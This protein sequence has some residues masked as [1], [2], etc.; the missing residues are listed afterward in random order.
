MRADHVGLGRA[1]VVVQAGRRQAREHRADGR[2]QAQLL[3]G[4]DHLGEVFAQAGDGGVVGVGQRIGQRAQRQ[5]RQVQALDPT[6]VQGAGERGEVVAQS[7]FGDDQGRA[8]AQRAEDFLERDVETE[9]GEL[10]GAQARAE[11]AALPAQQ[12]QQRRVRH[13]HA[14]GAAG[15]SGGVDHV[16][17]ALRVVAVRVPGVAVG[18]GGLRVGRE[19]GAVVHGDPGPIV[20]VARIVQAQRAPSGCVVQARS[21]RGIVQQQ[22]QPCARIVGVQRQV[23]SAGLE[24]GQHR[25]HR[26]ESALGADRDAVAGDDAERAQAP[27][28][29][30]GAGVERG[31]AQRASGMFQCRRMRCALGLA[32]EQRVHAAALGGVFV[33]GVRGRRN[34]VVRT[35]L[36]HGL[37]AMVG[38]SVGDPAPQ[39]RWRYSQ[40]AQRR[41][42]SRS[43]GGL[44]AGSSSSVMALPTTVSP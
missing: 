28:Q 1:V 20:A 9:R 7:G 35:D 3:A 34:R 11:L 21:G 26:R 42:C 14:L 2:G 12:V 31:V 41:R 43:S 17:R 30:L 25:H 19:V 18:C 29:P 10:Q 5:V 27:R 44:A 8:F 39:P 36:V 22:V 32:F 4:D 38:E 33:A 23:G 37:V 6:F 15:R 24:R 40:R 13:R 16:G